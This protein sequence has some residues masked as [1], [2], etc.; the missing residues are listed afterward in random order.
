MLTLPEALSNCVVPPVGIVGWWP[1][2]G[3]PNNEAQGSD[4][5]MYEGVSYV[6]GMV[7]RAFHFDGTRG[8]V[9]VPP[10]PSLNL[11][12]AVT[13]DVWVKHE[14]IGQQVQRYLTLSPE[15]A[16][17]RYG[18]NA[19]F[20]FSI[21]VGGRFYELHPGIPPK[22]GVYH[23]VAGVYSGTAQSLYIDG[24]LVA[25]QAVIGTLDPPLSGGVVLSST[26]EPM[27]GDLDEPTIYARALTSAEV[28]AIYEAGPSGKC[29][30]IEIILQPE[31]Q[32][33]L[34]GQDVT[35]RVRAT[36]GDS[37]SYQWSY[38]GN[39]IVG[40]TSADLLIRG[41]DFS[42]PAR[43]TAVISNPV[44]V[45]TS[46]NAIITVANGTSHLDAQSLSDESVQV[47]ISGRPGIYC[48]QKSTNLS[49]WVTWLPVTNLYGSMSITTLP[50]EGQATFY[51]ASL[52]PCET[53]VTDATT[54][55]GRVMCGYNGWFRCPGDDTNV[56]AGWPENGTNMWIHWSSA[57]NRIGPETLTFDLWPDMDE[58]AFSERYGAPGFTQ[59]D[60]SQAHLFSSVNRRTI[61]RHFDWMRDY[62]IDGVFL[63]RFVID[64][65]GR[66]WMTNVIHTARAAANRTG[67]TFAIAYDIALASPTNLYSLITN[68][69]TRMVDAER[70]TEDSRY[71]HHNGK[72]VVLVWGY[73]TSQL[74][75]TEVGNQII[76]FFKGDTRYK[77][78]LIG[79][80]DWTWR[81]NADPKWA[82]MFRRFDA[83]CPWNVGNYYFEG[84]NGYANTSYW[85]DDIAE[86]RKAGMMYLPVIYP[87]FSWDNLKK[88]PPGTSKIPRLGGDFFWRQ[89]YDAANLGLDMAFVAMFDE[90]DE[91]TAIFKV[92]NNPPR[93]GYFVTYEGK[94]SD[95]Y[96]RLTGE[97][98]RVLRGER[99]NSRNIPINP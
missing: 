69:W 33:V 32:T 71:L 72:P 61:N 93:E 26:A 78:T 1:G 74:P 83:I 46:S 31:S 5:V 27:S 43:F 20:Y 55:H 97:G 84:T 39:L 30:P 17:I 99:A 40:E 10:T 85:K 24:Q 11:S 3:S 67:R 80:G 6:E 19:G 23:H 12:N 91:G 8:F 50:K 48:L 62:G 79:G 76:D 88:L 13:L 35:L 98:T 94:P 60:G 41:A 66:P 38:H 52:G 34:N 70:I 63:E 36:G 90:V 68:D 28:R 49:D 86:A 22:V 9:T 4:G 82:S 57:W 87:G 2:D 96:L 59:A 89:F 64:T 75:S 42:T 56:W 77:A 14:Q 73:Y 92:T 58:Y 29:K 21:K 44:D 7:G 45:K 65:A 51:K 16:Q 15:K 18:G 53:P 81:S 54:L 95:W 47:S 25:S 37:L